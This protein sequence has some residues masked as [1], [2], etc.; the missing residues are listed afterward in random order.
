MQFHY[1]EIV[2]LI[3]KEKTALGS[4]SAVANKC[5]VSDASISKMVN[6]QWE[7]MDN[8]FRKVAAALDWRPAGWQDVET[9]NTR[10]LHQLFQDCQNIR[11]V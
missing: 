3:Q 5:G 4:F 10:L 2:E 6:G 9:T 7:K 1:G 8:M 11:I